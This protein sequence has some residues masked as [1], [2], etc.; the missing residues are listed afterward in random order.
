M[1]TFVLDVA[2][3]HLLILRSPTDDELLVLMGV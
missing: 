1:R 2:E 3:V